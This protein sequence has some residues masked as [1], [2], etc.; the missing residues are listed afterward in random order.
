MLR[1]GWPRVLI[2][3]Y[4]VATLFSILVTA[5]HYWFDAVG[6]IV[7]LVAGFLLGRPLSRILPGLP[8]P[9]SPA[10]EPSSAVLR[11]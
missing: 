8:S 3:L 7:V 6:G 10:P 4:P 9:V 1:R 5:N 11:R 2:A